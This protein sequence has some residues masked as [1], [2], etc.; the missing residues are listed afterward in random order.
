MKKTSDYILWLLFICLIIGIGYQWSVFSFSTPPDETI[1]KPLYIQ[2]ND[3]TI[4]ELHSELVIEKTALPL[5]QIDLVKKEKTITNKSA[6]QDHLINIKLSGTI[7]FDRLSF[8]E[9][10]NEQITNYQFNPDNPEQHPVRFI[11]VNLRDTDHNII[12][13]TYTN[14]LGQYQFDINIY[15]YLND[16]YIEVVSQ[17]HLNDNNNSSIII[18]VENQG[19]AYQE[20]TNNKNLYYAASQSFSLLEG[21]NQQDIH[22]DTG[23]HPTLRE[24]EPQFSAAQP[25]AILDTL[26]KG[27]LYLKDNNIPFSNNRQLL[28]VHWSQDPD[29]IEESTGYYNRS[30][31]LIYISGNN[32]Q[33]TEMKPISTISEW[34]EHTILHEF[35]HYYLAKIVGRDDTQAGIHTAFGFGS[36]TLALSEGLANS[37]AKTILEDWQTKRVSFDFDKKQFV[38]PPQAIISNNTTQEKRTLVKQDGEVYQRPLFDFSPFIEETISYFILSIIDPNSEYSARTTKLNDDIGMPGLHKALLDN[39]NH[40]A[41]MT[42]YSLADSLKKQ[43]PQQSFSIDELGEQLDLNFNDAWGRKQ[44]PLNSHVIGS[45]NELLPEEVQYPIYQIVKAE[46]SNSITFNGS[47]QSLSPKRPGTLRYLTFEAPKNGIIQAYIPNI[48]DDNEHT[49]AF[50]FNIVQQGNIVGTSRHSENDNLNYSVFNAQQG[51][52]YIIRVFDELFNQQEIK[53]EQTIITKI[54]MEYRTPPIN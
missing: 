49:H 44:L 18:N 16:Y 32:A 38:T 48:V 9:S 28:T 4:H 31:N 27:F 25:F 35:G 51:K 1:E 7:A 17:M 47:L 52:T 33:D 53:S 5:E 54:I 20:Q 23:W 36:L 34:N 43:Y 26:T 15:V 3:Q 6:N 14:E 8:I 45:H 19:N 41:L 29:I 21:D 50:S 40:P 24:F 30:R 22:L 46:Q 12:A 42:I 2:S 39:V 10:T 11:R 13:R 37:L